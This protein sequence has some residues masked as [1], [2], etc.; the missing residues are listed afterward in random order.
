MNKF[1]IWVKTSTP[2]TEPT[3]VPLP[4]ASAVPPMMTAAI[5]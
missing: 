1:V 5:A 3:I 4:P 2:S